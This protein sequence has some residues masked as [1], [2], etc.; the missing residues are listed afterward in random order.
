[1]LKNELL[2]GFAVA[3]GTG[4][5]IAVQ[6]AFLSRSGANVGAARSG[7]LTTVTGAVLAT[8][9][10][11]FLWRQNPL[12]WQWTTSTWIALILGGAL[13]TA[14]LVGISFSSQRV[15]V[16]AA[17]ASILL[18]QMLVSVIIDSRGL[19]STAAIPLSIE[20]VLGLLLLGGGV[21]LLLSRQ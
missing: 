1:M 16:T 3:L 14:A 11:I 17:L 18:G 8:A 21:Y 6:T 20:R 12:D 13:G 4:S 5:V 7:L 2:M 19:G 10:L 15:G 9:I